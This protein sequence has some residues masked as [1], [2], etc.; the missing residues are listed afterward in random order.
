MLCDV[1]EPRALE[2]LA[3]I[4]DELKR[5][6]W[7]TLIPAG[8]VLAGGSSRLTG[9]VELAERF[10]SLPVR[11]GL[12]RGPAGMPKELVQP[13]YATAVGLLMYGARARHQVASRPETLVAKIKSMFAG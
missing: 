12:P 4:R 13:E 7:D 1:V 3:L 11:L 5:A 6:G 10:F 2:L 9:L 8:L